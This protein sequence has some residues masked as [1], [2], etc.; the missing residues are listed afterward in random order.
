MVTPLTNRDALD[1]A[2]LERLVEHIV[3]GG[4]H[5]L[6]I[7]GTTGEAPSLSHRLQRELIDR[8]LGQVAERV[9]VFVGVPDPSFE[10]SVRLASYAADAGAAA[11][12]ASAPYFFPYEQSELIDYVEQIVSEVSLPI[13][14]YNFPVMTK[15]WFDVETVERLA[16]IEQVV[17]FKDS[18]GNLDYYEA[19]CRATAHRKDWSMLFGPEDMLAESIRL[20]GHGGVCGGAN[21]FPSL[22]VELYEAAVAQDTERVDALQTQVLELNRFYGECPVSMS[23]I[24]CLK[25]ALADMGVCADTLAGSPS[26]YRAADRL[27][28]GPSL[29]SLSKSIE[30]AVDAARKQGLHL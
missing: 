13:V 5:G 25:S 29:A 11:I 22:F 19:V 27:L 8:T 4:V 12:V 21:L 30:D 2:G 23:V 17:G 20:G 9:P 7:L 14:L 28:T 18:S 3:S 15:V 6:F 24:K 26:S 1:V 16:A 10:E